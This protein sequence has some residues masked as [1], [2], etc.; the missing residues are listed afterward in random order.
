[1]IDFRSSRRV[2]LLPCHIPN[3]PSLK[4][5]VGIFAAGVTGASA[6]GIITAI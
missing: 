2:Q 6:G 1:M 4:Q 5:T 3:E